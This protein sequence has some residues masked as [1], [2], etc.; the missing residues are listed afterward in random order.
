MWRRRCRRGRLTPESPWRRRRVSWVGNEGE[1]HQQGQ[2]T[3]NWICGS[4]QTRPLCG[5]QWA[6]MRDGEHWVHWQ[7]ATASEV[8]GWTVFQVVPSRFPGPQGRTISCQSAR[9]G[10]ESLSWTSA[11]RMWKTRLEI[12]GRTWGRLFHGGTALHQ[13]SHS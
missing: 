2:S 13:N 4:P 3:M 1:G 5:G 7:P 12:H 10:L 11:E 9:T 8:G 6:G